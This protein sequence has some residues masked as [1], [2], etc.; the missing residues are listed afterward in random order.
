M[1]ITNIHRFTELF[2]T[3]YFIMMQL[4]IRRPLMS[5]TSSSHTVDT[6]KSAL[7][8]GISPKHISKWMKIHNG[9]LLFYK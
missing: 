1:L 7:P 9:S 5:P 3:W 4:H 8:H 6:A 2:K